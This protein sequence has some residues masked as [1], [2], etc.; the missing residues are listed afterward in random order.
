MCVSVVFGVQLIHTD[1][2]RII[3]LASI[4]RSWTESIDRQTIHNLLSAVCFF[5][6]LF[7]WR[8]FRN[9][10][11]NKWT[12]MTVFIWAAAIYLYINIHIHFHCYQSISTQYCIHI[13]LYVFF[14]FDFRNIAASH[15]ET[16][17]TTNKLFLQSSEHLQIIT[18]YKW[19]NTKYRYFS[20]FTCLFIKQFTIHTHTH[21]HTK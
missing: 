8:Y 9:N 16:T 7:D 20:S 10:N 6:H 19:T 15:S 18:L 2:Q 21:T 17:I 5:F 13:V 12:T 1:C 4:Y 11:T 3:Y 14:P